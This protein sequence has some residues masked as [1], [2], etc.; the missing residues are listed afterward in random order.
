MNKMRKLALFLLA[1]LST[2]AIAGGCTL[3]GGSSTNSS[4]PDNSSVT[5]EQPSENSSTPDTSNGET[6][7]SS[8]DSGKEEDEDVVIPHDVCE[9]EWALTKPFS[10]TA[11]GEMAEVCKYDKSHVKNA[12]VIPARGHD[13]NDNGLCECGQTPTIPTLPTQ[14]YI[15]P[16]A[17]PNYSLHN[18]E[19]T[20]MEMYNRYTL[21]VDTPY[22]A[23]LQTT[24]WYDDNT[25]S[26][27]TEYAFWFHFSIPEP[28]QYAIV[29]HSN[30][31]NLTITRY[32][33]NTQYVNPA[34]LEGRIMD[35]GNFISTFSCNETYFNEEWITVACIRGIEEGQKVNFSIVR[36]DEPAWASQTISQVMLAKDINGQKAPEG[37]IG[38]KP[39]EVPYDAE[40]IY[41]S[42]T[43]GYYHLATGEV[44]FAAIS[45]PS[46]RQFGNGSTAL[47]TLSTVEGTVSNFNIHI[48]NLPSG[49]KLVYNYLSMIMADPTGEGLSYN[50][51]S[52]QAQANGDGLYPVTQELYEFL[53]L[54]A[55]K[56]QPYAKPAAAYADN[57]WLA[58][59]YYYKVLP[60][61]SAEYAETFTGTGDYS[62]TQ[63]DA[64]EDY[65]FTV[66]APN[67][68][69]AIYTITVNTYNV[70]MYINGVQYANTKDDLRIVNVPFKVGRQ[71]I[72]FYCRD[73][74]MSSRPIE[75][76]IAEASGSK[77]NPILVES[78][79]TALTATPIQAQ[80]VDGYAYEVYY[81]YTATADGTLTLNSDNADAIIQ[82]G[83][84]TLEEGTVSV[85]VTAGET[86]FFYVSN[87][88]GANV[89]LI[90]AFTAAV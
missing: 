16:T 88:D 35:D 66:T 27:Y 5:S 1:T 84:S 72:T 57:A 83:V 60:L 76:T 61:G 45:K 32:D 47:T 21:A 14:G 73:T 2:L 42:E 78:T 75:F 15:T 67:G 40:G 65:Y 55:E 36:I 26:Y 43:D 25:L 51:N 30:P 52:Y 74:L 20:S 34:K 56:Q 8:S 79:Q 6:S 37:D 7:D 54:H 82:L 90:L 80:T 71:A 18:K 50:E 22:T 89:D 17:D 31:N 69:D 63:Y 24:E 59:C 68:A 12:T 23:E 58:L 64:Y 3:G 85:D 77:G 48:S 4:T 10:C 39:T 11:D 41:F 19:L 33:A 87:A 44:M 9:Y 62:V 28:G 38:T 29:S 81:A 86:V 13:Y 53:H 49:D 70:I 46:P